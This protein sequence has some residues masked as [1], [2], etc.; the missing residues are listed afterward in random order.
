MGPK[1]GHS[2]YDLAIPAVAGWNE[3]WKA[4]VSKWAGD[5]Q[6]YDNQAKPERMLLGTE[7]QINQG[8]KVAGSLAFDWILFGELM[9]RFHAAKVATTSV[10]TSP[11][12]YYPPT[13]VCMG[14]DVAEFRKLVMP[15]AQFFRKKGFNRSTRY[16]WSKLIPHGS[17]FRAKPVFNRDWTIPR[18]RRSAKSTS[19]TQSPFS[20]TTTLRRPPKQRFNSIQTSSC[21]LCLRIN[22]R[23]QRRLFVARAETTST[24]QRATSTK[25]PRAVCCT[26]IGRS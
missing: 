11:S 2:W 13:A 22:M 24:S 16:G 20:K 19:S 15:I 9:K 7:F 17:V 10:A 8:I 4:G 6:V 26:G 18:S 14:N 25:A 1:V 5:V 23:A 21:S 12:A 3:F